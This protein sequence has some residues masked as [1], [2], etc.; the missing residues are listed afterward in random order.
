AFRWVME[1]KLNGATLM[2][3]DP[4]FTRTTAMADI[5]AP[6]R[7]GSDIAFLGGLI[8]YV[9]NSKRW[10]EEPFFKDYVVNYTNAAN[11]IH[12]DFK[13]PEDLAG[14][15]SG[16]GPYEEGAWGLDGFIG[17]YNP[18]TWQYA[19]DA[20]T[21]QPSATPPGGPPYDDLVQALVKPPAKR[22]E[23]LQDPLCA[24]QLVK[25]HYARYT[26]EMVEQITG[27]PKDRM[28]QVAETLLNNSGPDK[29]SM[30]CY[31]MG[32][33]QHTDGP[34][35]IGTAALLQLLLG[36]FGRPGGGILALR[37][38]ANIQGSTDIPTLYHSIQGYMNAPSAL[39]KHATVA[40]YLQTETVPTGYWGNTPKFFISYLKSMWGDAATPENDFA[41][42][43]HPRII[44]DHS[45][46]PMMVAMSEGN[47]RGMIAVGQ[48]PAVGG[49]NASFQR[50][51]MANLDWL[52]IKDNFETETAAFWY[53]SPEAQSG[54]LPPEENMTEVFFFPSAQVGETEGT[55]TNTQRLIQYHFK[56]ADPPGDARSDLWFTYNLGKRL[57]ALYKDSTN[58]RDAGFQ[59]LVWDYDPDPDEV[60][61]WK[62]KDEPSV[63]KIIREING[64]VTGE[65]DN[66]LASFG[67][68]K[69]DGS[70]TAASWIYTGIYPK[71][72]IENVRAAH[73]DPTPQ[74]AELNGKTL[75]GAAL[76]W[77]F[78]WPANRRILYNRASARPDGSPWSQDKAWVWWDANALDE[79]SG[80]TGKWVGLDV[81][82]FSLT[83]APDAPATAGATGLDALSGTDPF[84]MKADGR[85]WLFTP[86][87]LLDGPL[88]THYEPIES[89]VG[90]LLYP[91][92]PNSPVLKQWDVPNNTA[93]PA[94]S[95]DYPYVLTTYRLTEHHLTG[96]M[97]RW[98]PWL[99]ELQ[100]ELFTEISPELAAEKGIANLDRV[101][102]ITPRSE[103]FAKALVT[104]RLQPLQV[105][106][107]T[108]HLVGIPWCFGYQGLVTGS[109]PNDLTLMVGDPN[110]SIHESK[111]FVCNLEK[112]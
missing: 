67:L 25:K 79:A 62:V 33:T 10:S 9:I 95:P 39:K 56:A 94:G 87:G 93:A 88:P 35:T 13:G 48:N 81:P 6:L 102:L 23:T 21:G 96:A 31:A 32:W 47:V 11:I 64:F 27:C 99:A 101:R 80:K 45:H 103:I 17:A 83:K 55:F 24:F 76:N 22:D 49:Q 59:N 112:A 28:I 36:N 5:H 98:L 19:R 71:P 38:H 110:V 34:Q 97:T 8:N 107:K 37:G 74:S 78:S 60:S 12:P 91:E 75:E 61:A 52:V 109:A 89:P 68:L 92:Q 86:T 53:K 54:A 72:G 20:A 4:R 30:V 29:T 41:Y 65:P 57:K 7:S 40:E 90:N 2:H 73:R 42:G 1:A 82:D 84:I 43:W 14:V 51:A 77:G 26:P 100:P 104:R 16:L 108:L 50:K 70:T 44:G 63:L 111:A 69:D 3:V 105:A 106:G 85:G 46:M 58:P 18:S 15:F 66:Q